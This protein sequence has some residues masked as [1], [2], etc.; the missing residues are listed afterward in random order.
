MEKA[1]IYTKRLVLRTLHDNDR[2]D[3]LKILMNDS[4]KETYMIPHFPTVA[5]AEPLLQRLTT[6]SSDSNR[7][8][9]GISVHDRIIGFMHDVEIKDGKIE[10]GYVIH[11]QYQNNGYATEALVALIDHLH[12]CGFHTV[13]A[14]YFQGNIASR[15][16]MEKAGM[17]KSAYEDDIEYRGKT[18]HCIYFESIR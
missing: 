6:L 10:V 5:D 3:L 8:V 7:Y 14:G 9:Y 2:D 13:T 12:G 11:P 17:T 4:I 18:H 15:R 1:S 16:V